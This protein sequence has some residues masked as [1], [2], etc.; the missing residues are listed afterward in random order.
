MIVVMVMGMFTGIFGKIT[1]GMGFK[2]TLTAGGAEI[3][4]VVL[5]SNAAVR[6]VGQGWPSRT[7]TTFMQYVAWSGG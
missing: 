3:K 5:V 7:R 4:L 2:F 1:I 6:P